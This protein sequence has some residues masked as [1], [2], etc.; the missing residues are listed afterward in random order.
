[1]IDYKMKIIGCTGTIDQVTQVIDRINIHA[2]KNNVEIQL[3]D[4]QMIFGKQH[5]ISAFEHAI[6]AFERG[7]NATHSLGMEVLLYASGERQIKKAIKKMG[8]KKESKSIVAI[9]LHHSGFHEKLNSFI[10]EFL[11]Q[12][13][14]EKNNNVIFPDKSMLEEYGINQQAISSVKNDQV[15]HLVLE[16]VA[17]VDVIKK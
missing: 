1:M 11:S 4:A 10:T 6:R 2:E 16:K 17:L 13:H 8:I 14:L 7:E 9:I 12:F 5:L 15:F 3:F